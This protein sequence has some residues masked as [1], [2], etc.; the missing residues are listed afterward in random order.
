P[1]FLAAF[2]RGGDRLASTGRHLAINFLLRQAA[3]GGFDF[4]IDAL[5]VE[6]GKSGGWRGRSY[7]RWDRSL[8]VGRRRGRGGN[9]DRWGNVRLLRI[10][11]GELSTGSNEG[12][13][14]CQMRSSK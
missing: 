12:L 11:H 1:P 14:I 9:G 6:P 13:D 5:L 3:H 2:L 10:A 8:D 4:A 7:R